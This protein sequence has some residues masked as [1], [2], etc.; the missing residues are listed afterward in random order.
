MEPIVLSDQSGKWSQVIIS[1]LIF[2]ELIEAQGH[3]KGHKNKEIQTTTKFL[4]W[5]A[6]DSTLHM[7]RAK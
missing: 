5:N 2:N 3:N 1:N 4:A 6:N 7:T